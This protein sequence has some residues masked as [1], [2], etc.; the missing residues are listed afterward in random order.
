MRGG[1][2]ATGAMEKGEGKDKRHGG[3]L[4]AKEEGSL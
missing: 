3:R 1:C 4:K 2:L